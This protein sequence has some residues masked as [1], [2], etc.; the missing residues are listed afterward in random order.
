[1]TN[2][3]ASF[4]HSWAIELWPSDV[5]PGTV[6]RARYMVR[7]HRNELIAAGALVR[8]GRELVVLGA[9]YSRWL[10]NQMEKVTGFPAIPP[11]VRRKAAARMARTEVLSAPNVTPDLYAAL[12]GAA[13][14]LSALAVCLPQGTE[15]QRYADDE[16]RKCDDALNNAE[17]RP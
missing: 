9:P 16:A 14:A 10:Q 1:M 3:Q 15:M 7:A 4:P 12:K 13:E 6:S 2:R 5:H 8:V 17:G 11:N